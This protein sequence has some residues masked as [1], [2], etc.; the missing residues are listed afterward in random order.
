MPALC[1]SRAARDYDR[2]LP[3]VRA[4][5][6]NGTGQLGDGTTVHSNTPVSASGLT[7]VICA[8]RLREGVWRAPQ[9]VVISAS[10]IAIRIRILMGRLLSLVQLLVVGPAAPSLRPL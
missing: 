5:G 8:W 3:L 1:H 2:S 7:G 9:S 10:A 4:W 6:V